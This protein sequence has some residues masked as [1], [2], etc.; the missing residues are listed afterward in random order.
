M[1]HLSKFAVF[2]ETDHE[3]N[4]MFEILWKILWKIIV[5]FNFKKKNIS[6]LDLQIQHIA[7][8]SSILMLN[9]SL[10]IIIYMY[11]GNIWSIPRS[12]LE[13][14]RVWSCTF[15]L[16]KLGLAKKSELESGKRPSRVPVSNTIDIRLWIKATTGCPWSSSSLAFSLVSVGQSHH[17]PMWLYVGGVAVHRG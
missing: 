3:T 15:G 1:V 8:D 10:L 14:S 4:F 9:L 11:L 16:R 5:K 6:L 17:K 12:I 13:L 7:H 2:Y